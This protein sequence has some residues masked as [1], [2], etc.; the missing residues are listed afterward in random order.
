MAFVLPEDKKLKFWT[1]REFILSQ[2]SVDLKTL[3]RFAGKT[4]SFSIAVPAARLYTRASFRAI[5]SCSKS[6]H[7]PLYVVGDLL[8]E[9][10]YWRF[11]DN[12]QG[13]LPWFDARDVVISTFSD[14]SNSGWG[15]VFSE[16][17]GNSVQ[18]SFCAQAYP[19]GWCCA[20]FMFLLRVTS[21][22]PPPGLSFPVIVGCPLVSGWSLKNAGALT[23]SI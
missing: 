9:I 17:S 20:W 10:Q 4:T 7:K 19:Q 18:R 8:R 12:C 21:L 1:L 2:K 15:G 5:S 23:P 13:C 16:K 22:I 6:P 3:Q 11:L 14:A